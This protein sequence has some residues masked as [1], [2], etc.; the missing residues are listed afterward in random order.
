MHTMQMTLSEDE[1]CGLK[2]LLDDIADMIDPP[3]KKGGAA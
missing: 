1:C 3:A 2:C